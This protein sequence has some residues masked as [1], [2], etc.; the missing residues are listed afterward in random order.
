MKPR[1]APR[2][3]A[4]TATILLAEDDKT[5][6]DLVRFLLELE[7]YGVLAT[8]RG[9]AALEVG[10]RHRGPI[11]LLLTDVMMPGMKGEELAE[12]MMALRPGIRV[13]FMSGA[14]GREL[15]RASGCLREA[16]FIRK[17]FSPDLLARTVRQIL[18]MPRAN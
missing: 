15:T 12:R 6:M 3:P 4:D 5:V 7:G 14:T 2:R 8:E 1:A 13:L 17:P 9:E 11:H 10:L 16:G 18:S